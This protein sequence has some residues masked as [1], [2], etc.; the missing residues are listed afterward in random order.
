MHVLPVNRC[1]NYT[2]NKSNLSKPIQS[3]NQNSIS[4]TGKKIDW[5]VWGPVA[6]VFGTVFTVNCCNRI[7]Q[8]NIEKLEDYRG[9][10]KV[11]NSSETKNGIPVEQ[12]NALFDTYL[13]VNK[14][15][16]HDHI[17][18]YLMSADNKNLVMVDF[19]NS[20]TLLTQKAPSHFIDKKGDVYKIEEDYGNDDFKVV[21]NSTSEQGNSMVIERYFTCNGVEIPEKYKEEVLLA[22][23]EAKAIDFVRNLQRYD[24]FKHF[25]ANALINIT[26]KM[27]LSDLEVLEKKDDNYNLFFNTKNNAYGVNIKKL[28]GKN[29]FVGI[30]TKLTP[31]GQTDSYLF[32]MVFLCTDKS[33]KLLISHMNIQDDSKDL[34]DKSKREI[35]VSETPK[36][37]HSFVDNDGNLTNQTATQIDKLIATSTKDVV[38][39][40]SPKGSSKIL[41]VS[42]RGKAIE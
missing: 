42:V 36:A 4:F 11:Q 1:P 39:Y 41:D 8:N 20:E 2:F 19:S 27:G 9:E 28:E 32:K 34:L 5:D 6:G 24:V 40:S 30:A 13:Q 12:L 33:H 29:A 17:P 21:V 7:A 15:N 23:A 16:R 10:I 37:F 22:S 31:E 25:D 3:S 14:L 18:V 38:I 35:L 26:A